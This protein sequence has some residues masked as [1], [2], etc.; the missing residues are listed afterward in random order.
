MKNYFYFLNLLLLVAL[1]TLFLSCDN[2]DDE[3]NKELMITIASEQRAYDGDLGFSPYFVKLEGF[4][5]WRAF[6]YISGFEHEAGY[7]YQLRVWQ[8]KWHNGEIA[9]ASIYRYKLLEVL[10]KVKKDS[11]DLPVQTAFLLVASRKSTDP[12]KPYYARFMDE[13]DWT[14][15]PEIEGFEYEEGY[16][17][18]LL[19][20]RKFNGSNA[21]EKF[22]YTHLETFQKIKKNSEGL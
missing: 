2:D 6:D 22:S 17:H 11:E 18:S 4:D 5:E 13:K 8:E 1:P 7:E 12:E 16:E 19:V 15:F 9:D 10:S 20:S 14:L 3:H 21:P